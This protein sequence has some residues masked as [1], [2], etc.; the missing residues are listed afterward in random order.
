[1]ALLQR[2]ALRDLCKLRIIFFFVKKLMFI[3]NSKHGTSFDF[4]LVKYFFMFIV[5]FCCTGQF[6]T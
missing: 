6:Y 1:M 5:I 4:M 2:Q 3:I